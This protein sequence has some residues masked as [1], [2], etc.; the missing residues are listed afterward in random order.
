MDE[1][2][3]ELE[4]ELKALRPQRLSARAADRIGAALAADAPRRAPWSAATNLASWQWLGWRIGGA[5]AALAL[6]AALVA[7]APPRR[8]PSRAAEPE[9]ALPY[10]PV[11]ATNVL[12]E[13]K[14]EGYVDVGA[15][16]PARQVRYRYVDTYTWR[17]PR[18]NASLKWSVPR[19]EIRVVPASLN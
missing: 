10:R 2:C 1:S 9:P 14:E 4:H 11:A 15:A 8:A 3:P 18:G 17:S 6:L 16:T 12:Y 5:A 19:D 7:V 13:L